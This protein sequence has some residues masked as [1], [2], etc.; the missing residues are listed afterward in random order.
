MSLN[1]STNYISL[2]IITTNLKRRFNSLVNTIK[3]FKKF[4][5]TNFDEIILS[6]DKLENYGET[7]S[8]KEIID[9]LDNNNILS[10][11]QIFFKKGEGMISNQCNGV[12][13]SKGNI[14]IYSEDDIIMK[15]LPSRKNIIE[16]T[17]NGVINYN[18]DLLYSGK[19]R[20]EDIELYKIGNKYDEKNFIISNDEYFYKKD[21]SRYSKEFN[22]YG[23]GRNLSITFPCAIMRKK[24]FTQV[25]NEV[26]NLNYDFHIEAAFSHVVN[27]SFLETYIFCTSNIIPLEVPWLYRDNSNEIAVSSETID[28]TLSKLSLLKKRNIILYNDRI[29]SKNYSFVRKSS[30]T[31][32]DLIIKIKNNKHFMYSRYNDGE[33]IAMTGFNHYNNKL[34]SNTT[35][36]FG[37]IDEHKYF[38]DMGDILLKSVNNNLNNL[39]NS[40][41]KYLFQSKLEEWLLNEKCGCTKLNNNYIK[42]IKWNVSII[43]EDFSDYLWTMPNKFIE[44]INVIN[45]KKIIYIGPYWIKK[46][47]ILNILHFIEIP[48]KNCWLKKD[49]IIN[50]IRKYMK[51]YNDIIFLFSAS[52][53]T[54]AIIEILKLEFLDKHFAIDVGSTFDNFVTNDEIN[55]RNINPLL[56]FTGNRQEHLKKIVSVFNN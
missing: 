18:K 10:S 22:R 8:E 19:N 21:K 32:N 53:S 15:Q 16:L 17:K 23:S 40:Q 29:L 34:I 31:I 46:C 42:D 14:I 12:G 45:S 4:Y 26:I 6:I 47:S 51:K 41:N 48:T 54:N 35:D 38:K 36:D 43:E 56:G 39:L 33:F 30:L 11:K 1:I 2:V 37:N 20:D 13:L 44:F 3:S 25:Y 28:R 27:T 50:D 5:K 9:F 55:L 24:I 7:Y 49:K 52:M